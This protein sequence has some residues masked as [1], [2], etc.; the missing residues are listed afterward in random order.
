MN[1]D[2]H[3]VDTHFDTD[4]VI[5]KYEL[6]HST[7]DM[8]NITD[9]RNFKFKTLF[10]YLYSWFLM[11]LSVIL[12][13]VDIYTCLN[14][15]VFKK[16][17]TT[18]DYTPYNYNVAKWI[19]TGC[20]IFQFLL[21]IYHWIWA[22]KAIRSKNIAFN[23]LN[24]IAKLMYTIYSFDYFC[25]FNTIDPDNTFDSFSFLIHEQLDC[26]LQILVADTPRQ[27]INILTLRYYATDGEKSWDVLANIK[28]I[29]THN[30]RL[31][32]ILSF[33]SLSLVIWSIFFFKFLFAII[34]YIPMF[35]KLKKKGYTSFNKYCCVVVNN[36]VRFSIVK[37]RNKFDKLLDS[38]LDLSKP[39][40]L[41]NLNDSDYN[42]NYKYKQ[43]ETV[44]NRNQ[45]LPQYNNENP[46]NSTDDLE[47]P[48]L[49]ELNK[50]YSLESNNSQQRLVQLVSNSYN[51]PVQ[52]KTYSQESQI[53]N[54][55]NSSHKRPVQGKTYSQESQISSASGD[56]E[57]PFIPQS[58][59]GLTNNI[60]GGYFKPK[61]VK[62]LFTQGDQPSNS[63]INLSDKDYQKVYGS[64]NYSD[65]NLQAIPHRNFYQENNSKQNLINNQF[66]DDDITNYPIPKN[67]INHNQAINHNQ[68]IN[69]NQ[70]FNHT[71][72]QYSKVPYPD[73]STDLSERSK[74]KLPYP[75]RGISMLDERY[76]YQNLDNR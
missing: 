49:P 27:V 51:R 9:Y 61:P 75:E 10:W 44:Y 33:I 13:A 22:I 14:I 45:S 2:H 73:D 32:I 18:N 42:M 55:S 66:T 35:F 36:I 65:P 12:L 56:P 64:N 74:P 58:K 70:A 1:T 19:F 16:W 15:L 52:E 21:I 25:L 24:Q 47:N 37:K 30:P 8:I 5:D 3:F 4:K 28:H 26:A 23:F 54:A 60:S 20:I 48:F 29:Y 41:S 6:D 40:E 43:A 59:D 72:H 67:P 62:K 31:S 53:S 50:A 34:I 46:F 69:H 11:F 76:K 68:G 39:F 17:G 38:S 57:N 7:F 71:R 63:K